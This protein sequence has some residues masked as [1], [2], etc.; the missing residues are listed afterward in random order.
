MATT[1][2]V[3][4]LPNVCC[5]H[6]TASLTCTHYTD[7]R[8]VRKVALHIHELGHLQGLKVLH[9]RALLSSAARCLKCVNPM[10]AGKR[11]AS[12]VMGLCKAI[13]KQMRLDLGEVTRQVVVAGAH[14]TDAEMLERDMRAHDLLASSDRVY[15]KPRSAKATAAV[16]VRRAPR[17]SL[18]E[19]RE[20]PVAGA[21]GSSSDPCSSSTAAVAAP[22]AEDFERLK[23]PFSA[24]ATSHVGF[25]EPLAASLAGKKRARDAR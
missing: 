17:P 12:E 11:P 14:G 9:A 18:T 7:Q 19:D 23:A 15:Q 3:P 6:T 20:G 25:F 16:L 21:A 24:L 1:P 10:I 13:C 5:A 4:E 8:K 2:R 22:S